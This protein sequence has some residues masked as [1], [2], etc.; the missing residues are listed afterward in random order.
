M[1]GLFEFEGKKY[2]W[3]NCKGFMVNS[4]TQITEDD[5]SKDFEKHKEDVF[6]VLEIPGQKIF[7]E[8][9]EVAET[10]KTTTKKG[11]K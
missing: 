3:N 1:D 7:V 9:T 5:L 4:F 11:G 8:V 2:K 10:E 6:A